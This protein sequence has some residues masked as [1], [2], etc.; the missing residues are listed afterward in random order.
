MNLKT[1]R[2]DFTQT[3]KCVKTRDLQPFFPVK[4]LGKL[5][6]LALQPYGLLEI[7]S[8]TSVVQWNH[9]IL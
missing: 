6:F 9:I 7:L 1:R 5:V 3:R 2:L 4:D 8:S